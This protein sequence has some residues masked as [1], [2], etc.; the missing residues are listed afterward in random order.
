M[1]LFSV[2][3][4]DSIIEAVSVPVLASSLRII[5]RW[6]VMIASFVLDTGKVTPCVIVSRTGKFTKSDRM[7]CV[8]RR[9][10]RCYSASNGGQ[11]VLWRVVKFR[12]ALEGD[13]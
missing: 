5:S 10:K 12:V 8:R 4:V 7:R 6:S 11:Q 13:H 3:A 9:N 2:G 1:Q